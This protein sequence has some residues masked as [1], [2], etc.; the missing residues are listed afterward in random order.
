M[1]KGNKVKVKHAETDGSKYTQQS[2]H[3]TKLGHHQIMQVSGGG[4]AV[5]EDIYA[6]NFL[7]QAR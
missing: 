2:I 6:G 7:L 1:A 3:P 4:V 5:S